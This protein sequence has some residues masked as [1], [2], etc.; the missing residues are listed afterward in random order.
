MSD[1]IERRVTDMLVR[2][3]QR[4]IA[5][6]TGD[7]LLREDLGLDSLAVVE[8]LFE[9]ESMLGAP[10]QDEWLRECRTVRDVIEAVRREHPVLASQWEED[11]KEPSFTERPALAVGVG[12]GAV[13][14]AAQ[15]VSPSGLLK[16]DANRAPTETQTGGASEG[17][18]ARGALGAGDRRLGSRI[19]YDLPLS[20]VY[21][22]RDDYE[23]RVTG[24]TL[25][26]A[27]TGLAMTCDSIFDEVEQG[28][29]KICSPGFRDTA[30][31][32]ARLVWRNENK[33]SYGFQFLDVPESELT[34]W[35]NFVNACPVAL[36]DRRQRERRAIQ[37]GLSSEENLMYPHPGKNRRIVS[38]RI[39]DLRSELVS[40]VQENCPATVED[41]I[42]RPKDLD[43]THSSIRER[44]EWLSSRTHSGFE[45]MTVFSEDPANMRGN[46]ENLI[47]V[48]QEPV[49]V[50][51]PLKVNGD[52]ARGTFYV[53]MATTEGALVYTY[54]SGMQLVSLA[55]GINVHILK[56]E[57]NISPVFVFENIRMSQ[58]FVKWL[59][60]NFEKIKKV[61]ESTTTHGKLLRLEPYVFG[62]DVVVKFIYSTG[63]AMGL[64]MINFAT[65][66]ACKFIIPMVQPEAFYLRSN[67][68]S[69]KKV[70]AHNY[71]VSSFGKSVVA[72]AVIPRSLLKRLY[73]IYPEAME[74]YC[75]LAFRSSAYAGM[76]GMNAHAANGLTAIFIACGQDPAHVVDSQVSVSACEVTS[77]GDLY[78]SLAI[79]N[80]VVGTVGGGVSLGAQRECLSLLDC[81]G[82]GKA[83]KFAEI[84][85][86][87]VLAGE[88]A[89]TAA[90]VTGTF[91][92]AHKR[93]GRKSN[94]STIHKGNQ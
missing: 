40:S 53:P 36:V 18:A 59:T 7:L 24:R 94:G 17:H 62:H 22:C 50:A 4:P 42:P 16:T 38:R 6:V 86:A 82:T 56:D 39:A 60:Q 79:P 37:K 2:R 65:E 5:N 31:F 83:K 9:I 69:V 90:V 14:R 8:I 57:V 3:A 46:V 20:F 77:G 51:G 48:V 55:G 81:Y 41:F 13:S 28:T 76:I 26:L 66:E 33:T 23:R 10:V 70:S 32:R 44:R 34:Q 71:A 93:Y 19:K 64:N 91:A 58:T 47:G 63:D 80:L 74:K 45:H 29:I 78:I 30:S 75:Y 84:V 89:V 49:G 87:A 25:N 85:A 52:H 54:T 73:G 35:S 27:P 21:E 1:S 88:L 67:F 43:Y 68:S 61:A 92:D 11:E 15:R 12:N 72:D